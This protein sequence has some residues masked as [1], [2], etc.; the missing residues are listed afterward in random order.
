MVA[1]D[2]VVVAEAAASKDLD[3]DSV[4]RPVIH[5]RRGGQLAALFFV[6][7]NGA[8]RMPQQPLSTG[9]E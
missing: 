7:S 9:T 5:I 1:A 2:V 6:R 4:L 8:A 3:P